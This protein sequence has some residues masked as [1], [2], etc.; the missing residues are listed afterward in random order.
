MFWKGGLFAGFFYYIFPTFHTCSLKSSENRCLTF[1]AAFTFFFGNT[2]YFTVENIKQNQSQWLL[3]SSV[4]LSPFVML[5]NQGDWE[6]FKHLCRN[7]SPLPQTSVYFTT[8]WTLGKK[9]VATN[10]YYFSK[11]R[12]KHAAFTFA[13]SNVCY[14]FS[15]LRQ[16]TWSEENFFYGLRW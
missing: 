16:E 11:W 10:I 9:I 14:L 4:S 5:V 2:R 3:I 12:S 1:K 6:Y 7:F 15:C 8:T 13:T